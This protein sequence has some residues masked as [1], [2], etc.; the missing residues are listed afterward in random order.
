MSRRIAI[1]VLAASATLTVGPATADRECFAN[2]C[3][4]SEVAAPPAPEPAAPKATAVVPSP[5]V[6][7]EPKI[8][9]AAIPPSA[10]AMA[11]EAVAARPPAAPD[12][13]KVM[14]SPLAPTVPKVAAPKPATGVP[15]T[16]DDAR[17]A[18]SARAHPQMVVDPAPRPQAQGFGDDAQIQQSPLRPAPRYSE[19]ARPPAFAGKRV[20]L[21]SAAPSRAAPVKAADEA[22]ASVPARAYAKHGVVVTQP[23]QVYGGYRIHRGVPIYVLAPD[24]KIITIDPQD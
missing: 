21:P 9:D 17:A 24:A 10:T 3:N 1:W 7:A 2:L 11:K 19:D 5:V 4:L 6:Q 12:P 18:M 14:L 15:V 22:T 13:V 20:P 23:H 8:V 16:A